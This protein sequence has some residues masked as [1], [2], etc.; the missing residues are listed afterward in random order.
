MTTTT[1]ELTREESDRLVRQLTIALGPSQAQR[2]LIAI[3]ES[4]AGIFM[5]E[6]AK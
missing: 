6:E 3:S 5:T 1:R 4:G 2:A